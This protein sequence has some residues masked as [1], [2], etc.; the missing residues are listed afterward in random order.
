VKYADDIL[1]SHLPEKK[2]KNAQEA[3][4][5]AEGAFAELD[6]RVPVELHELWAQQEKSALENRATDPKSMDIFEVQLEKGIYLLG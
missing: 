2:L 4:M 1:H 6:T 5:S 3:L